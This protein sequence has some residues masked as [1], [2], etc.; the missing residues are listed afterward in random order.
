MPLRVRLG[1]VFALGTAVVI[2]TV[3]LGFLIQLRISL[4]ATVD[5][6]LRGRAEAISQELTTDGVRALRLTEDED[7]VQVLTPNGRV[8]ASSPALGP[9]PVLD[10]AEREAALARP[11]GNA[12]TLRFTAGS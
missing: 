7:P 11:P 6:G 3:G 2:A 9:G 4:D 10:A 8:V 12:G 1:L 5:A